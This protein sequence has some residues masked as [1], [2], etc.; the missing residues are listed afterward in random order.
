MTKFYSSK[1]NTI[2]SSK[3][4]RD[5]DKII[6]GLLLECGILRQNL[7]LPGQKTNA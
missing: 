3:I 5:R 7:N 1:E 4:N 2:C 6:I